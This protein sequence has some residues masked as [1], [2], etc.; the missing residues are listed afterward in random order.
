MMRGAVLLL[1]CTAAQAAEVLPRWEAGAGA[2]VAS[3]PAY[4]GSTDRTVRV[5]AFPYLIYR[6]ERLRVDGNSADWRLVRS[7]KFDMDMGIA[8]SLPA[9]SRDVTARAG[10]PD[11]GL[12]GEV[13]P[14]MR[15]R[16]DKSTELSVP[17]RAVFEFRGGVQHRGWTIEP[18][19]TRDLGTYFDW[20]VRGY[21]GVVLGD[22]SVNRYFYE[23]APRYA[24]ADRPAYTAKGGL[25]VTRFGL[26]GSHDWDEDVRL[27]AFVRMD[28]Y[29]G[30][31]NRA[32]PLMQQ[33]GGLSAG[34]GV[35]WTLYRSSAPGGGQF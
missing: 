30:A 18:R 33:S 13:G 24:T 20:R 22:E 16:F 23:V 2:G 35:T 34:I 10:M 25:M 3:T 26:F 31:A 1:A 9:R 12:L 4:S 29:H 27:S 19:L 7:E 8:G 11:L 28:S 32:S 6:G 21:A 17:V 14:R 15:Y 5:L